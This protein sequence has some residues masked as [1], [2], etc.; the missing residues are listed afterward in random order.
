MYLR[1][2]ASETAVDGAPSDIYEHTRE[3]ITRVH[4]SDVI[5]AREWRA[6]F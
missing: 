3:L 4:L 6:L 2:A 5:W 1:D